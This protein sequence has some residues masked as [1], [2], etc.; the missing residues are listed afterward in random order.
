[1]DTIYERLSNVNI[2]YIVMVIVVIL[3]MFYMLYSYFNTKKTYDQEKKEHMV[4][5]NSN[6]KLELYYTTW[7][8]ASTRFMPEWE[9]FKEY[10]KK[11]DLNLTIRE[12][13]CD[14]DKDRCSNIPHFPCI[15]LV[16]S[17]GDKGMMEDNYPLNKDGLI[18]FVKD[19]L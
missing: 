17:N 7:C 13:V 4:N 8:G 3:T 10:V 18:Q 15:I 6:G 14:D 5:D 19:K 9:S 1:M 2:L 12:I 16:K 11:S